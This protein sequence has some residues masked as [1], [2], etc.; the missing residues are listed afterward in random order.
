MSV[1]PKNLIIHESWHEIQFIANGKSHDFCLLCVFSNFSFI[2]STS[3]AICQGANWV[4]TNFGQEIIKN[5]NFHLCCWNEKFIS[6]AGNLQMCRSVCMCFCLW[7]NYNLWPFVAATSW[8]YFP[9]FSRHWLGRNEENVVKENRINDEYLGLSMV[10]PKTH[11]FPSRL[12]LLSALL[13]LRLDELVNIILQ[14]KRNKKH[15][16]KNKS[17]PP[18]L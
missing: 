4:F 5:S 13:L 11:K 12:W 14:K 7:K 18:Y 16:N 6:V 8:L 10:W 3:L 2:S 15:Y 1:V 9:F 17:K